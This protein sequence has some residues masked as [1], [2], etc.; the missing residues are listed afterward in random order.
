MSLFEIEAPPLRSHKYDQHE[1]LHPVCPHFRYCFIINKLSERMP[2]L[3]TRIGMGPGPQIPHSVGVGGMMDHQPMLRPSRGSGILPVQLPRKNPELMK[4]TDEAQSLRADSERLSREMTRISGELQHDYSDFTNSLRPPS[5][6]A[7]ARITQLGAKIVQLSSETRPSA[8]DALVA[9]CKADAIALHNAFDS[10]HGTAKLSMER[11][12][13]EEVDI[14]YDASQA[15]TKEARARDIIVLLNDLISSQNRELATQRDRINTAMHAAKIAREA[16]DE[17]QRKLDSA[18]SGRDLRNAFLGPLGDAL[19][20]G[21]LNSQINA[22]KGA[23][24]DAEN[25]LSTAQQDYKSAEDAVNDARGEVDRINGYLPDLQ[26][27]R[28]TFRRE[29]TQFDTLHGKMH[30]FVNLCLDV[31][32]FFGSL[33]AQSSPMQFVHTAKGLADMVLKVQGIVESNVKLAGPFLT[34][35]DGLD[36]TL[37]QIAQSTVPPGPIDELM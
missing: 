17:A 29:R 31:A 19:D 22:A 14:T 37:K 16:R 11:A 10:A 34:A 26:N 35:P 23:L 6:K 36:A 24:N 3:N 18:K 20:I 30:D 28:E 1:G 9:G 15:E 12:A 2:V 4:L 21:G 32:V 7:I 13:K 33:T 8:R 25:N 27:L 5:D